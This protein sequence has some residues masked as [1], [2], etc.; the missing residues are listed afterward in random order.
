MS[1]EFVEQVTT[2]G[3]HRFLADGVHYR[4]LMDIRAATPDWSQWC[5]V[6]SQYAVASEERGAL[7]LSRSLTRTAAK[8]FARAALYFHY[9]QNLYYDDPALKRETHDRKVSAFK[10]AAPLLDPPLEP[11]EITF[12]GIEIIEHSADRTIEVF[13]PWHAEPGLALAGTVECQ[14]GKA[15]LGTQIVH[16]QIVFLGRIQP[17]EKDHARGVRP[18]RRQAQVSRH[19]DTVERDL[20]RLERWIEEQRRALEHRHLAIVRCP[21]QRRIVVVKILR[22][23][24]VHRGTLELLRR[25]AGERSAERQRP[26]FF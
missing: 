13:A 15:A 22:V 25:R 5:A 9:A 2:Q 4:D 12:D 1:R 21:L 24:K 7:A 19:L 8:E 23:V 3:I 10:R 18:P 20:H 26:A 16:D 11:V 14:R 6:W 17:A